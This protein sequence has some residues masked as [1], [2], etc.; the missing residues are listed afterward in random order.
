MKHKEAVFSVFLT[1]VLL[2]TPLVADA[3]QMGKGR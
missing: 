3:E 1:A 2:A